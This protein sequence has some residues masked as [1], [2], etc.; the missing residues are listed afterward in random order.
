MDGRRS[1]V[2]MVVMAATI[3][4]DVRASRYVI[5]GAPVNPNGKPSAV[6]ACKQTPPPPKGGNVIQHGSIVCG[7]QSFK[8]LLT[9]ILQ[10]RHLEDRLEQHPQSTSVLSGIPAPSKT[11]LSR[12]CL[13]RR[14]VDKSNRALRWS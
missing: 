9:I 4:E 13:P 10:P 11:F 5:T 2:V 6:C 14:F 12:F 3:G 7:R 8:Q 1:T